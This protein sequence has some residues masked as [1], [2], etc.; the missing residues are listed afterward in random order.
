MTA[1]EDVVVARRRSYAGD[2]EAVRS[3]ADLHLKCTSHIMSAYAFRI[4][5]MERY[6]RVK[7]TISNMRGR[8]EIKRSATI[9]VDSINAR[10]NAACVRALRGTAD[11]LT[12]G[13]TKKRAPD[14]GSSNHE[15]DENAGSINVPMED[16][17]P[18]H[19]YPTARDV[20]LL[21]LLRGAARALPRSWRGLRESCPT[22]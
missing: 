21:P 3:F 7:K 22:S 18:S 6:T 12:G 9:G 1:E 16:Q 20:A 11:A 14:H 5:I 10:A 4:K 19:G 13:T 2:P 17:P 8:G 15:D